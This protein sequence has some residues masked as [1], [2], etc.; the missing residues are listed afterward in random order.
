[1]EYVNCNGS[2]IPV[3]VLT[4][5]LGAGKTTLLNRILTVTPGVRTAV[6][7]NDFGSVSIDAA[8]VKG[9][10]DNLI[11]LSNGC[12]CCEMSDHMVESIQ[13]ILSR[14]TP[15][16]HIILEASGIADPSSI[17][18]KLSCPTL[19]RRVRLDNVICVVDAEQVFEHPDY[20]AL[21]ELK[22]RQIVAAD[23]VVLNKI[24][25]AT[26]LKSARVR[27][28]AR[29]YAKKVH[30]VE[31]SFCRVE[32]EILLSV[33]R[34]TPERQL[35]FAS[36]GLTDPFITTH[37]ENFDTWSYQTHLPLSID[38]V[39]NMASNLPEDILRCKGVLYCYDT[40]TKPVI[41]HIVGDRCDIHF[42]EEWDQHPPK[43]Q[44]IAIGAKGTFNNEQFQD[45]LDNC[46]IDAEVYY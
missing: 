28:W 30:I 17:I 1:M 38:A 15:I 19:K 41:L 35:I 13:Q 34:F 45:M 27:A 37:S 23:I 25:L 22:L 10:N 21:L 26:P 14:P 11:T 12:V 44:I 6:I 4:G 24:D 31:T 20:P 9:I 29:S 39:K 36:Q 40:P 3:T 33:G 32:P 43:S 18:E 16:E 7:V 5:F 8:L 2:A 42:Q 46:W